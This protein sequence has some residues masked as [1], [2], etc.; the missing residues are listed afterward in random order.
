MHPLAIISV[1]LYGEVLP[2]QNG[3]P[4]RVT[5][6]WKYGYKSAKSIA[7]IRLVEKE[8]PTTWNI[9]WPQAYGFYSNINP[10]VDHP[11]H[12]QGVE[13]RLGSSIFGQRIPTRM[14]NGYD[15]VAS[16]YT[17]MDLQKYH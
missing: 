15:Q 9:S 5:V 8:P 10:Q 14:F 6:P 13:F 7:K 3:A 11:T 12:R 16:L 17:G 4:L 2:P 1:G